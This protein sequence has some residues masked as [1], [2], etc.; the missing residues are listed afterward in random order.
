M[1]IIDFVLII[2]AVLLLLV[3]SWHSIFTGN[4][5]LEIKYALGSI[6]CLSVFRV[7]K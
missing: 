5:L 2:M 4:V 3:A 7:D 6:L 1:K